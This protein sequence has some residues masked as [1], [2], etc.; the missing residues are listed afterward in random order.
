M[1][2]FPRMRLRG[3]R[4][5]ETTKPFRLALRDLVIEHGFATR[6]GNANWSAF[7]AQL[8]E[9]HYETLRR[10]VAGDRAPSTRLME[11]CARVLDIPPEYFLEYRV[12]L[13]Q[14][15]FDPGTVG[16]EQALLNLEAWAKAR[17]RS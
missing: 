6:T 10:V 12:Y 13:A 4:Q 1:L 9:L 8:R 5:M 17:R 14:R 7:A 11:A 15:D 2:S 16:I 3:L